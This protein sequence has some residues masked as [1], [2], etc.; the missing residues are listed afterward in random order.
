MHCPIIEMAA[1]REGLAVRMKGQSLDHAWAAIGNLPF[2][3]RLERAG[4]HVPELDQSVWAPCRGERL[5]IG[6]E[7]E[8]NAIAHFDIVRIAAAVIGIQQQAGRAGGEIPQ[9]DLVVERYGGQRLAVGGQGAVPDPP[10]LLGQA[11]DQTLA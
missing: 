4:F 2:E 7:D 6:A 9:A 3:G 1:D 10:F 5:A 11:P 8:M